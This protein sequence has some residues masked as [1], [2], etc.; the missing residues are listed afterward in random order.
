MKKV[1]FGAAFIAASLLAPDALHAATPEPDAPRATALEPTRAGLAFS[2]GVSYSPS[3]V[4]FCLLTGILLLDYDRVW[5]HDAPETLRFRVEYTL[6]AITEPR[7]RL[8]TSANMI[9]QLYYPGMSAGRVRPYLGGGIGVIYT[10]FKVEGQGLRFNFNPLI[11]TGVEFGPDPA[12]FIEA[13]LHHIS[14]G[15]LDDENTGVNSVQL[16]LGRYF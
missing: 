12:W 6:G 11:T 9:A 4:D 15:G 16:M 8:M 3:G 7:T 5:P 2:C 13:R 10:D 14:N 1:I